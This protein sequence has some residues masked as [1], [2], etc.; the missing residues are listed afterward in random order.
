MCINHYIR[1]YRGA[2]SKCL[3]ITTTTTKTRHHSVWKSSINSTWMCLCSMANEWN[4]QFHWTKVKTDDNVK[5]LCVFCGC[6][7]VFCVCVWR[8]RQNI[9][10]DIGRERRRDKPTTTTTSRPEFTCHLLFFSI[11]ILA[12]QRSSDHQTKVSYSILTR[13]SSSSSMHVERSDHI[14]KSL[15][16]FSCY[17]FFLFCLLYFVVV[18]VILFRRE[19]RL[20]IIY[21]TMAAA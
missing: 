20:T 1:R 17:F 12:Y 21:A 16:F 13:I 10:H 5:C 4:L 15:M 19:T 9:E 14:T 6:V 3:H 18:P 2:D 8:R 11:I 7:S